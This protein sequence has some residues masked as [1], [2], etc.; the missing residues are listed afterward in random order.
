MFINVEGIEA[1]IGIEYV[2]I[3]A[4]IEQK[5]ITKIWLIFILAVRN[6]LL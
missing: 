4:K 2:G 6:H 1:K 3:E 5:K